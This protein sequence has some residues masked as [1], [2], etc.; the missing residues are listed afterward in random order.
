M[1]SFCLQNRSSKGCFCMMWNGVLLDPVSFFVILR[2]DVT[3]TCLCFGQFTGHHEG[4]KVRLEAGLR[5]CRRGWRRGNRVQVLGG[6]FIGRDIYWGGERI[7]CDSKCLP[8]MMINSIDR[9]RECWGKMLPPHFGIDL[10]LIH[11]CGSV[12]SWAQKRNLRQR[13]GIGGLHPCDTWEGVVW[14]DKGKENETTQT[15]KWGWGE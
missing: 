12:R 6:T 3:S 4:S 14:E 15:W 2:M 9:G 10:P 13:F 5:G 7:Y 8:R 1:N 11:S